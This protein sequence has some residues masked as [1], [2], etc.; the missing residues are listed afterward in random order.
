[1][2]SQPEVFVYRIPPRSNAAGYKASEWDLQTPLWTGSLVITAKKN[3]LYIRLLNPNNREVFAE[4]K[5]KQG[6][7][8]GIVEAVLDSSRYFVLR[9]E[10]NQRTA[11]IGLGYNDRNDASEFN[12][13]LHDFQRRLDQEVQAEKMKKDFEEKPKADFSLQPGKTIH[14]NLPIKK[15]SGQS[16]STHSTTSGSDNGGGF[17]GGNSDVFLLPPP[18]GMKRK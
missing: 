8:S 3:D 10:N 1:V 16:T 18:P 7:V 2:L 9:V 4:C 12:I 17:G 11:F 6:G 5:L 14:V 15:G 13:T